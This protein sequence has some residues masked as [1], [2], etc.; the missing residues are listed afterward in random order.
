MP[1]ECTVLVVLSPLVK[2]KHEP[3]AARQRFHV[4]GVYLDELARVGED[5]ADPSERVE[6]FRDGLRNRTIVRILVRYAELCQVLA[7]DSGRKEREQGVD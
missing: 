5:M 7:R 1:A 6:H 3:V 4:L 2:H